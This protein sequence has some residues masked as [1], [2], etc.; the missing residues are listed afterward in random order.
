MV[1]YY[2]YCFLYR[3]VADLQ[4][5]NNEPAIQTAQM[6]HSPINKC[7]G[8]ADRRRTVEKELLL[9][10]VSEQ[11]P[12]DAQA[13]IYKYNTV[14]LVP[15]RLLGEWVPHRPLLPDSAETQRP[16]AQVLSCSSLVHLHSG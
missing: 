9:R 12:S 3:Q 13:S 7:K 5:N 11:L 2:F 6:C 4:S 1:L 8:A 10:Q 16:P 14:Q 15:K